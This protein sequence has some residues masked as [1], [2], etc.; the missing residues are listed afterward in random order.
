MTALV[1]DVTVYG[2]GPSALMVTHELAARG[3]SVALVGPAPAGAWPVVAEGGIDDG[4]DPAAHAR[5]T[6]LGG[7]YLAARAPVRAMC[8]HA[9][10]LWTWLGKAG[11]PF[12]RDE[13]GK[14]LRRRLEGTLS[15]RAVFVEARTVAIVTDLLDR[16]LAAFG[17]KVTR[18]GHHAL[19]TLARDD[20]GAVVGCVVEDR[21]SGDRVTIA[22]NAVVIAT[23][24]IEKSFAPSPAAL[25]TESALAVCMRAGAVLANLELLQPSIAIWRESGS[26]GPRRFLCASLR[27]EGARVW[28]PRH[29]DDARP[30]REIPKAERDYLGPADGDMDASALTDHRVAEQLLARFAAGGGVWDREL[31]TTRKLAFLDVS[32]LPRAHLTTRAGSE[33]SQIARLSGADPFLEPLLAMPSLTCRLGG[34]WVDHATNASGAMLLDSPRTHA[35]SLA[36]LYACG[37]ACHQYHGAGRIGGNGLVADLFGAHAAAVGA[38]AYRAACIGNSRTAS[39]SGA[40]TTALDNAVTLQN[41]GS[42]SSERSVPRLHEELRATLSAHVGLTSDNDRGRVDND[43]LTALLGALD[44]LG[45][46]ALKAPSDSSI[47]SATAHREFADCLLLARVTAH[48]ARARAESRG[49]FVRVD[50]GRERPRDVLAILT[51]GGAIQLLDSVR[52]QSAG[53][54]HERSA[55][56]DPDGL[57]DPMPP[58]NQRASDLDAAHSPTFDAKEPTP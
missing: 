21:T 22:S 1:A 53:A 16:A 58:G 9:A 5:D 25:A 15:T 51:D 20:D 36:G 6:L 4:S 12:M 17:G 34:L 41:T 31:R 11:V 33:L 44:L 57:D 54:H 30:G 55:S 46:A 35:T 43:K 3:L 50:G 26:P 2:G 40:M 37:G 56:I 49:V 10:S 45:E 29:A 48:S 47:S 23:G 32:H 14:P 7:D 27:G 28:L 52:Y 38:M 39:V 18:L 19:T 42:T 13:Q 8:E 24:G